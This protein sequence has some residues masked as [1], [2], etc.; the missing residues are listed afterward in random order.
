[1]VTNEAND[2]ATFEQVR[3]S[4]ERFSE[5]LVDA[6]RTKCST[7]NVRLAV[8]IEAR[9]KTWDSISAKLAQRAKPY[10]T[11]RELQDLVG[12]RV[13]VAFSTD[14][15][16][17]RRAIA[18]AADIVRAYDTSHRLSEDQFGYSAA[19]YVVKLRGVDTEASLS[20][21]VAEVQLRTAAQHLWAQASH[22]FQY[23]SSEG[24]PPA[25]RRAVNRIAALLE[26]VDAEFVRLVQARED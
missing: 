12:V 4:L 16:E 1:M 19:H 15:A 3:P 18:S 25:L 6:I 24:T 21:M 23:K 8:P 10:R 9:V 14:L 20:D 7:N 5:C 17:A 22:I 2:A 26:I 13:V 11:F